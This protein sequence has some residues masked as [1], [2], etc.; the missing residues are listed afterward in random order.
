MTPQIN[1]KPFNLEAAK[2]GKPVMTRSGLKVRIICTDRINGHYPVTALVMD[3]DG[4]TVVSYTTLGEY[5]HDNGEPHSRDLVMASEEVIRYVHIFQ[6][7]R[8]GDLI[9][10]PVLT[11]EELKTVDYDTYGFDYITTQKLTFNV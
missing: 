10:S 2:T 4:E 11:I 9:A 3:E 5:Y 7:R 8:T 6:N 1:H